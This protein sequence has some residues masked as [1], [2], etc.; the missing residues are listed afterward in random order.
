MLFF[1]SRLFM[2]PLRTR[3]FGSQF[4]AIPLLVCCFLT[5]SFSQ[6]TS[7]SDFNS[8]SAAAATERESGKTDDAIR[9][10][11]RGVQ[12]RADWA[13]GW[14][15]L[16]TLLYERKQFP[17][18]RSAFEQVVQLLPDMGAAWNF[19]G[20]CEFEE[21]AY[22]KSLTSLEKGRTL[23]GADDPEIARVATYHLGL[24]R[25]KTG[26][27]E[28]ATDL[29]TSSF[30][31]SQLP[32]QVKIALGMAMLRVPLLP[33]E[34]DPSRDSL[35]HAA[36]NAA[37]LMAKGETIEAVEALSALV[38]DYPN[39]PFLHYVLGKALASEGEFEEDL[40]QQ[41]SEA[42]ITPESALP[43]FEIHALELRLKHPDRA[44]QAHRKAQQLQAQPAGIDARIIA[45]YRNTAAAPALAGPGTNDAD[46]REAMGE[47]TGEDYPAAIVTLKRWL[48]TKPTDGTAWAVLGLSEFETKDYDNALI[49]LQRGRELGF[50]GTAES[51]QLANYRLAMLLNRSGQFERASSLESSTTMTSG[52]LAKEVQFMMGMT[53]LRIALFPE[54]VE[55]GKQPIV[56]KAGETAALLQ[57]SQYESAFA[58]FQAMLKQAPGMPYLHYAYGTALIAISR[59]EEA[60]TEMHAE[61]KISP[62]SELPYVRLA[63]IALR[64]RRPDDVLSPAQQALKIAPG[65]A[66]AHYLLGRAN[67]QLGH[68]EI[69]LQELEVASR[70]AP[71]SAEIHFNLAKAYAKAKLP[72]KAEVERATFKELNE[73][74][75]R[76][77]SHNGNQAYEGPREASDLSAVDPSGAASPK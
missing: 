16:G 13:E 62:G 74:A 26:Q 69:A 27:F 18:A 59:F 36:G 56:Q 68:N 34:V 70:I 24:L 45:F 65:S 2:I 77:R 6:E 10:Y 12:L 29:L 21:Q 71:K 61:I 54:Q 48:G 47:Y 52:P 51:V 20:L 42:R 9:D 76:Q 37:A 64:Q 72:E 8:V 32:E 3:N 57:S 22:D 60:E 41:Q 40:R 58:N 31:E 11:Q 44:S 33:N 55:A 49:H 15:Y 30:S 25:I 5:A 43:Q 73:A 1:D 35:I 53:L 7:N 67:L 63:S 19:L 39:A 38:K 66:E 17:E 4:L 75:E 14:W 46:W 28:A 23:G 50:G